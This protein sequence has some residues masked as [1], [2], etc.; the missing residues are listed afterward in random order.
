MDD[1]EELL[2]EFILESREA[3]DSIDDAFLALEAD[4]TD[5]DTVRG[6]F[7]SLHTI[8]GT[9]GFLGLQS[10][11]EVSHAGES[12]LALVRDGELEPTPEITEALLA[13]VD[14]LRT[15]LDLLSNG[16]LD[17]TESHAGLIEMLV[18]LRDGGSAPASSPEEPSPPAS[19]DRLT[20]TPEPEYTTVE[21]VS[22]NEPVDTNDPESPRTRIPLGK[23]LVERGVISSAQL[24]QAANLQH[25]GDT[26]MIGE[27]LVALGATT[28]AEISRAVDAQQQETLAMGGASA[29]ISDDASIRVDV[30]LLDRI[31][32]MVGE[33]VLSRNQLVQAADS[34]SDIS[35]STQELA[36]ITSS[37][38]EEAL[39]TRM[40]RVATA[41][42]ALPRV[43][44][45]T[46]KASGKLVR[47]ETSGESIE[48]DRTIVEAIRDPLVHLVRNAVDHGI[49]A[50]DIR[51]RAGK[52]RQGTIS[53]RAIQDSSHV[54]IEVE[55]DGAG[56]DATRIGEKAIEKG[57][58]TSSDVRSMS[59]SELLSLILV[60]GFSTAQAVTT[61][62]GRGVGM[63]VVESN[64]RSVHGN[65]EVGSQ[66]GEGSCFRLVLPLT[67]AIVPALVVVGGDNLYAIPQAE[68]MELVRIRPSEMNERIVHVQGAPI[69]RLREQ[70]MPLVDL[71]QVIGTTSGADQSAMTIVVMQTGGTRFGLIVDRVSQA[72]EIVVKPISPEIQ[73]A[74]VYAGATVMSDG[75]AALILDVGGIAAS[76]G[77]SSKSMADD[78]ERTNST[79]TDD[80]LTIINSVAGGIKVAVP[81]QSV[82]RIAKIDPRSVEQA[83][84]HFVVQYRNGLLPLIDVR[85]VLGLSPIDPRAS[86]APLR[87]IVTSEDEDNSVGLVVDAVSTV[88]EVSGS[89]IDRLGAGDRP[90]V[91]GT[92]V[93]NAAVTHLLD[94]AT[95]VASIDRGR[96]DA[97]E[98]HPLGPP[99]TH[100]PLAVA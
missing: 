15:S 71:A 82:A 3:L 95:L 53:V 67:L 29:A 87:V 11:E 39:R 54:I 25:R 36:H 10:I 63:D 4:P 48:L 64:I 98:H 1:D 70:L 58:V 32:T 24:K 81:T 43:A 80:A 76:A 28:N 33:L 8:K 40:Q 55:D 6:I 68:V 83:G 46:G 86:E 62:S 57:I 19:P 59:E 47:L 5:L 18:S 91:L 75:S 20:A 73:S 97:I 89:A 93:A 41:W 44:R 90:G 74:G 42:R 99:G 13:T 85:T 65:L 26:R 69:L 21:S 77:V 88:A 27:L 12:L 31:V 45:D 56:I 100:E 94:V 79:P 16:E 9:S 60:P 92:V 49:E 7:R 51:E 52:P 50:P 72:E 84:D 23:L 14:E 22:E 66:L 61:V 35:R 17:D 2:A 30:G 34:G 96:V 37:L 38:H 78:V